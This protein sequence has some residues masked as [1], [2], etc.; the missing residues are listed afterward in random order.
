MNRSVERLCLPASGLSAG[1][2]VA[3]SGFTHPT[4]GSVR[5]PAAPT[6]LEGLRGSGLRT[7]TADIVAGPGDGVLFTT[8]Y[9]DRDGHAVG[10]GAAASTDDRDAVA[11]ARATVR[12]W[13]RCLR[14][15][16]ALIAAGPD[17]TD[18]RRLLAVVRRRVREFAARGDTVAQV[19]PAQI[20]L[21]GTVAV[22]TVADVTGLTGVDP[23]RLSFVIVPGTP[24]EEAAVVLAALRSRFPRLRGQHPDELGYAASDRQDAMRSVAAA[25]DLVLICGQP[26][27]VDTLRLGG[28]TGQPVQPVSDAGQ[29][30][31]EWL[32]AAAT[33]GIGV[34]ASARPGVVD[35]VVAVL[36]GLGPLSVARRS[37]RTE[38]AARVATTAA[39][40]TD[41]L[42]G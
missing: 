20:R 34:A 6:V 4:R 12:N 40:V 38:V 29:L 18:E 19:G 39:P 13:S 22:P 32:A 17:Q 7:R 24:V 21:P 41:W 33:V 15:R 31:A 35:D 3:A 9:L 42:A 5:C 11:A 8:S 36:S 28:W 30:R 27:H 25:S 23:E 2:V 26:A 37:V 14:T 10:L 1:E 16:R